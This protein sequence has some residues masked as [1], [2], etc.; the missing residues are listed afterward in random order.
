MVY[1]QIV[2]E[3][4]IK[5]LDRIF[6]YEVP[7]AFA[8]QVKI[9]SIVEIPFGA[10]N[11]MIK[12]YVVEM[13]DTIDFDP[14]KVKQISKVFDQVSYEKELIELASWM[15]VR[16][17]CTMPTALKTLLPTQPNVNKKTDEFIASL[18]A[19]AQLLNMIETLDGKKKFQARVRVLEVLLR[20][21]YIKKSVL[22]ESASVSQ[23]VLKTMMRDNIIKS[24]KE[25]HYRTPYDVDDYDVTEN[26]LANN[27]QQEAI[28]RINR[29]IDDEESNVYLLHGITGSGKTEVYLQAV[30]NV[31]EQGKSAIILIPE[32]GL[33]PLMVKRF[34]ERFGDV[35]GVMHS[36]L[37]AG[38][39]FDQWRLAKEGQIKIM[40]GPRSAIFTPFEHIGL[41][42][43]DEEHE[44]TY[45][46]E[47][48]PKYH[49]REVAVYRGHQHKC[50]VV[51]GSATP[52][53][54]SFYKAQNG[55]YQLIT[56]SERA[57]AVTDTEV[58]TVDM[59]QELAG[60]NT[61]MFSRPLF[62]AINEALEK[63]EQIILFLNQRGYAKFVSCRQCGHVIKCD[64][65]DVPYHYH[66]FKNQL[67]CHY[68]NKQMPMVN[69]C[70][71]CGSEHI[72][73][74]GVG[75]QKVQDMLTKTFK[76]A[77]VLRMDYDSTTGKHGHEKVL[78]AFERHEADILLGTQMVAK[79]HHFD[80]VTLVG[81]L[82]ADMSLYTNDFRASER[83]FQ[84]LTQVI[85]RSGRSH[86]A[87]KAIIQTYSPDHY[88]VQCSMNQDYER[89]YE[90]EIIYR[91]LMGYPPFKHIM[92]MMFTSTDERYIIK[93]SN[94]M[95]QRLMKYEVAGKLE[96]LGPAPATLSKVND[97]YRQ[98][99]YVKSD[100]YKA[101]TSLTH[102]IYKEMQEEDTQKKGSLMIDINP[103]MSY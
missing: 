4:S 3:I 26:L 85:G 25:D 13:T 96:L 30:Q 36:R 95:K 72:R 38:E 88:S 21:P 19:E 41:I 90:S 42:I 40:V 78:S 44:M 59:R 66:K 67:L 43:I 15:K 103:M 39:K 86:K 16:Y 58:S 97:I 57:A 89:F 17:N 49:A 93:L 70:P 74:F 47:M 76:R 8:Q 82:A 11:R 7:Q 71:N 94:N 12:G 46:S 60:G 5:S 65:C 99:I 6:T 27:E 84:L 61:S 87:G 100:A 37:S 34:V 24:A 77:R 23:S 45:K 73:E 55:T 80:N 92:L 63:K 20:R 50:P 52:L 9:G 14:A 68:C 28:H 32:I 91:K 69:A 18:L 29:S 83:T 1:A 22:I 64:H 54:E 35:V 98:L 10:G 48:P 75:T 53:V 2:T 31:L 62:N 101:L 56:L 79:G 51:L 81:V 102:Y 33:T